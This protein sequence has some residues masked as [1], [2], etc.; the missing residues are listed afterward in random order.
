[1]PGRGEIPPARQVRKGEMEITKQQAIEELYNIKL[2]F[3]RSI[4]EAEKVGDIYAKEALEDNKKS[5]AALSLAIKTLQ[6]GE[7]RI[8][9]LERKPK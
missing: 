2:Q 1:M 6:A 8:S 9:Q 5:A 7:G 3:D 4:A